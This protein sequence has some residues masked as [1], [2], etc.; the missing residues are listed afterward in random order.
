MEAAFSPPASF[1]LSFGGLICSRYLLLSWAIR[2]AAVRGVS[3]GCDGGGGSGDGGGSG[4]G[5][6]GGRPRGKKVGFSQ[7]TAQP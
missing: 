3:G 4:V 1:N 2:L 7:A 6:D 5:G